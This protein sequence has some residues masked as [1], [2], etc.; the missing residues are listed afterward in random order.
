MSQ[1][2]YDSLL[3]TDSSHTPEL[4]LVHAFARAGRLRRSAYELAT[5]EMLE[6]IYVE[7]LSDESEQR[8]AADD[9]P[10]TE[11]TLSAGPYTVSI[12]MT[13]SGTLQ[14]TQLSGPAGATLSISEQYIPLVLGTTV[15]IE[16]AA[17]PDSVSLMDLRGKTFTLR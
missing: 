12:V 13:P 3:Q 10:E 11:R 2:L 1:T 14:L 17:I 9:R 7:D 5:D 15:E 16:L 6:G 4:D 8:L